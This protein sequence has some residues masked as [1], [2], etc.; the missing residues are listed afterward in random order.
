M[1]STDSSRQQ[2]TRHDAALVDA[3]TDEPLT[4]NA[5][6]VLP[7]A[8]GLDDSQMQAVAR[9]LAVS[10]TA[11]VHPADSADR[12]LRYFTPT[13]EVDLCGHA[14]IATHAALYEAGEID[15]GTHTLATNVGT[16]E[17]TVQSD[18]TVWMT[19]NE[20]DIYECAVKFDRLADALGCDASAFEGVAEALPVAY[21]DTGLPFLVVPVSFLNDLGSMD[22]N[23]AA[24]EALADEHDTAGIYAFTFDT[25]SADTTLHGRCFV[26][27]AGVP[28]DPV[29]GT[30]SGACGAYLDHFGAFRGDGAEAIPGVDEDD[31][32]DS[33]PSGTDVSAEV[34]TPEEMVFEQG[35]YLDRPG[36]VRV[37][38]SGSGAP[39]V[40]GRA[41]RT[42]DGK[43]RIPEGE[44][45]EI[46]EA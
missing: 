4:G 37:R 31:V 1:D 9:E 44:D 45:D 19:Q 29:T 22:P 34:G 33:P 41:V 12:R 2:T 20:P 6:G 28:E 14:T 7:D 8:A 35:H 5:A 27:G 40:G 39:A 36:R 13:T 17:I 32:P 18:G 15:A 25:L 16:L 21:A 3:F 23:F 11:F 42:F 26:P 43:I 38:A 46:I 30:A 10:E 24:V